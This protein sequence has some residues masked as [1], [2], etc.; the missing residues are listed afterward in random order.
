MSEPTNV[1]K[2]LIRVVH[3][4]LE[5][6]DNF[7]FYK[8]KCPVCEDG[9]LLVTRDQSAGLMLS[10]FDRCVICGQA[11]WYTDDKIHGE[12]FAKVPMFELVGPPCEAPGCKGVLVDTLSLKTKMYSKQCAT[13]HAEFYVMPAREALAWAT[14]TIERVLKGEGIN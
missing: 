9:I 10:R 12:V 7:S 8:S 6:Y 14:R 11:F 1:N 13:C 5:R 4:E 3:A 2:P